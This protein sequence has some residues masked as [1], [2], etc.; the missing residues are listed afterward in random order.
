MAEVTT[1]K[2]Y[3]DANHARRDQGYIQAEIDHWLPVIKAAKVSA[4]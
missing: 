3:P 4:D 1:L 2:A